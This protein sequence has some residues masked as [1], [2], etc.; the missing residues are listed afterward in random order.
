MSHTIVVNSME[1]NYY[2]QYGEKQVSLTF[3]TLLCN[4]HANL[5][6][7]IQVQNVYITYI[8]HNANVEFLQ[9]EYVE[10]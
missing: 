4:F 6:G 3:I 10:H 2:E 8:N 9:A 1:K 5:V 7:F